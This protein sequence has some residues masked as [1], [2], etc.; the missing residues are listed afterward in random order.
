MSVHE[1]NYFNFSG[2]LGPWQEA[3]RDKYLVPSSA[4][5]FIHPRNTA[6]AVH[7]CG[8]MMVSVNYQLDITYTHLDGR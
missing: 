3:E 8:G 2:F 1:R 5:L 7:G 4:L 6:N